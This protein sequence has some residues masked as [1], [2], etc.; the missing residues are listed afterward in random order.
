MILGLNMLHGPNIPGLQSCHSR[1]IE[2]GDGFARMIR[3]LYM[4]VSA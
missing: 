2:G 1:K 3:P 4:M